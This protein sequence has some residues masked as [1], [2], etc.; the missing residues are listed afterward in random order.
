VLNKSYREGGERNILDGDAISEP[1]LWEKGS[2]GGH[3]E[4]ARYVNSEQDFEY[5]SRTASWRL[6]RLFKEFGWNFTTYAIAVALEKNPK[7]AKALVRDGHEIA[8]HGYRWL[9]IWEYGLEEDKAYIA[10]TLTALRDA[11]GKSSNCFG[12]RN[13]TLNK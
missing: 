11:S 10:K 7:F 6:M 12:C 4:N 9:D 3:R 1:Y 8:A 2:S 13:T 5:G